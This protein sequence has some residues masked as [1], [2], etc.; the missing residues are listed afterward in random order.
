MPSQVA[1]GGWCLYQHDATASRYLALY[2][3]VLINHH[4]KVQ[5]TAQSVSRPPALRMAQPDSRIRYNYMTRQSAAFR[6]SLIRGSFGHQGVRLTMQEPER[7]ILLWEAS[8][9]LHCGLVTSAGWACISA[10]PRPCFDRN[11]LQNLSPHPPSAITT[12]QLVNSTIG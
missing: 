7:L 10:S 8:N 6:I 5:R 9:P 1:N 11:R 2:M 4:T 3:V 12:L